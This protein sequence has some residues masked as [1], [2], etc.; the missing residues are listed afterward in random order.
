MRLPGLNRKAGRSL[1][2]AG[3]IVGAGLCAVCQEWVS[4][5][6]WPEPAIVDPGPICG[7][8][9]DAIV[10]FGGQDLSQWDGGDKWLV[11]DG[12]AISRGG[13]I[14]TKASFGDCQLHVEWASP[15]QVQGTGQG[16]GNSGIYLADRYEV[17][18]L[19]SFRNTTYVDG[20]AGAIYKTKPP[21][22]NAC[23]GPGEWQVFDIIYN[24]P[25][26]DSRGTLV[27]PGYLTV[28]HNGV[29][30]QNHTEILGETAWD[31]PPQSRP[32]GPAPI[33]L[34]FHGNPVRFRN[35]WLREIPE[36]QPRRPA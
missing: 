26:F 35:L 20:Q 24:A 31:S 30:I 36:P 10:L 34:Q 29:L 23:R 19:D 3:L 22:V 14:R 4:G 17:Q 5:I 13:D 32:H 1:L 6:I 2:A 12:V 28:L 11:Q 25:H 27:K 8:P 21:L 9:S 15:Q 33:R 18:I 7:P 16:R